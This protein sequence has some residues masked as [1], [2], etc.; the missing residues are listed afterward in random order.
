MHLPT[1]LLAAYLGLGLAFAVVFVCVGV[2]RID[3]TARGGAS[4]GFRLAI[5]PGTVAFWPLLAVRWLRGHSEPPEERSPHR[6]AA[7]A[8]CRVKQGDRA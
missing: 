4:W 7:C 5:L 3:P 8:A 6:C 2:T 1:I